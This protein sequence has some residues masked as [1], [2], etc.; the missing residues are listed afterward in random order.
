MSAATVLASLGVLA[1]GLALSR[2]FDA[3]PDSSPILPATE[4][5]AW[6]TDGRLLRPPRGG[7]LFLDFDGVL[8]PGCSGTFARLAQL[9]AFLLDHPMVDVIFSTSWREAASVEELALNFS[10]DLRDRFIGCTPVHTG[11]FARGSEVLFMVRQYG[12]RLFAAVDD[13]AR[14]FGP[15]FPGLVV[16]D[17]RV[18]LCDRDIAALSAILS[19]RL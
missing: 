7:V 13:Q 17:S 8:H 9:E 5:E 3:N 6:R 2:R 4:Q 15:S 14:L 16:T 1:V 11:A 18:G 10:A 19:D 12:I